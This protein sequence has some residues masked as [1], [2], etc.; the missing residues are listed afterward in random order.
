VEEDV[1]LI[2]ELRI[3]E[4]IGEHRARLSP[5][6]R[7]LWENTELLL[8]T[9]QLTHDPVAFGQQREAAMEKIQQSLDLPKEDQVGWTVLVTL[10]LGLR[11]SSLAESR[12]GVGIADK[13]RTGFV[14]KAAYE[15]AV[16]EGRTV[17]PEAEMPVD[18]ALALLK[19][20]YSPNVQE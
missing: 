12:W 18:E 13:F 7:E 16:A 8:E 9:S 4:L 19:A 2:D 6:G 17:T 3:M 10:F 5:A 11:A 14:I 1:R 15:K 20:P